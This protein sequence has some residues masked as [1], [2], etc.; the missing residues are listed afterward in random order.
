MPAI[1]W[2]LLTL[3]SGALACLLVTRLDRTRWAVRGVVGPYFAAPALLF[4]FFT[5]SALGDMWTRQARLAA[6]AS[7]EASA[8]GSLRRLA[9]EPGAA[10]AGLPA[11]VDCMAGAE[12]QVVSAPDDPT[13]AAA[14]SAAEAALYA[15]AMKPG[16]FAAGSAV[17][18]QFLASLERLRDSRHERRHL[19]HA[20]VP[21]AKLVMVLVLGVFTQLAIAWCHAGN[22]RATWLGVLLFS[23]SFAT[24]MLA[25]GA[26]G[27]ATAI[28]QGQPAQAAA[29]ST[30]R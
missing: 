6:L 27:R 16:C 21:A 28:S 29:T 25:L 12:A 13:R 17:Q 2:S 1:A 4:G 24:A 15:T 30:G 11:L 7:G 5:S 22:A 8:L 20:H 26:D 23:L 18:A 19:G 14:A 9:L 3:L 10:A